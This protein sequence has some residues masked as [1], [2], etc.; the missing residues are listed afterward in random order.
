[1]VTLIKKDFPEFLSEYLTSYL[2]NYKN[3]SKNTISSYCDTFKL[4]LKYCRDQKGIPVEKISFSLINQDTIFDFLDHIENERLV[5]INTRNQRLMA[6]RS[7]FKYVQA[8]SPENIL[9]CKKILN[10]PSK[11]YGAKSIN[12]LTKDEIELILKQPDIH[13]KNGRRDL[14]LLSLMYDTG[15]RVQEIIDLTPQDIRFDSPEFVRLFGKGRKTRDV[16]LLK[17]TAE[18]LYMYLKEN[19]LLD[20][21]AKCYPVFTNQ[22]KHKLT[23]FGAM[24]ILEKYC[25]K[26]QEENPLFNAHVT[27]HVLRHSKAMHL[28]QA[29]VDIIYIRDILG[30]VSIETTQ[31]YA[32]ADMSMKISALNTLGEVDAPA[33][34]VWLENKN[35]LEWLQNLG[36]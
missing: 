13:S 31:I 28:L 2:P 21:S 9:L 26:A 1:M 12:Y 10:I 19:L 17:N 15:A 6:I 4:F 27:P 7:F 30:H 5:S 20:E 14:A 36:K 25:K 24:Y 22:N 16:P 3:V 35:L 32:H 23:R 11:K 29:G 8:E 33:L 34:P 18:N